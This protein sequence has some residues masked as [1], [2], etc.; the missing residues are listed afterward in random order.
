MRAYL[1]ALDAEEGQS[2]LR[3]DSLGEKR[4]PYDVPYEKDA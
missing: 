4:F 3:G 2:A 1:G